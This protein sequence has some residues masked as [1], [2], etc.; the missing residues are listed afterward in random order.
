MPRSRKCDV[1]PVWHA[2]FPRRRP[3][4]GATH[5]RRSLVLFSA[6]SQSS[7]LLSD[8]DG[9]P[10]GQALL[11]ARSVLDIA[12][13]LTTGRGDIIASRLAHGGDHSG[14]HE[15]LGEEA[16]PVRGRTLQPRLREGIERDEVEL[17]S[18]LTRDIN[19]LPGMLVGVVDAV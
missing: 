11:D 6:V 4:P 5:A 14:I 2:G 3:T 13:Q 19:E 1:K 18:H 8:L 17:A 7:M 9:G 10:I 16:N 15:N 12:S